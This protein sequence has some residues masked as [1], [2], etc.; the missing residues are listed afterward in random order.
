MD[1]GAEFLTFE[2]CPAADVADWLALAEKRGRAEGAG[3]VEALIRKG[4]CFRMVLGGQT[5]GAYLLE[6][7]GAEVFILAAAGRADLNMTA[8]IDAAVCQMA[9]DFDTVAFCTIRPGLMKKT[10]ALGYK[11]EGNIFRK[12]IRP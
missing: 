1:A 9:Q 5:V 3:G 7:I 6:V 8:A 4:Q 12:R 2:P 11:R 10:A